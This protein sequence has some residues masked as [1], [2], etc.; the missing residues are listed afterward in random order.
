MVRDPEETVVIRPVIAVAA[1]ALLAFPVLPAGADSAEPVPTPGP[2]I[3]NGRTIL[4]NEGET[5]QERTLY[6]TSERAVGNVDGYQDQLQ[7]GDRLRMVPT[8]PTGTQDKVMTVR[9]TGVLG[10]ANFNRNPFQG[11]WMGRPTGEERIVC[12][13]ARVFAGTT[14]GS[15]GF[16]LWVDQ[17]AGT[18]QTRT[19][20]ATAAATANQISEYKADFGALDVS[21]VDNIVFQLDSV[22]PGGVAL[23]DS[24]ARPSSF[25]YVVVVPAP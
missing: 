18:G 24:V 20:T 4:L 23:Y 12:A 25:S 13:G 8:A 7:G 5:L 2:G 6:F 15:L 3:C 1:A 11:Y 19:A 10:N 9:P 14:T 17:L 22:T 16:Q 21:T